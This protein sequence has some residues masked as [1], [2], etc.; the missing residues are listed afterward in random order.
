MSDF[1]GASRGGRIKRD[2]G[3]HEEDFGARRGGAADSSDSDANGEIGS[4]LRC[5]NTA[6]VWRGSGMLART[7]YSDIH[8]SVTL[9]AGCTGLGVL[10][11][12]ESDVLCALST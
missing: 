8:T 7:V 1:T 6:A 4:A 2:A 12:R 3:F 9:P 11:R 10:W 5:S